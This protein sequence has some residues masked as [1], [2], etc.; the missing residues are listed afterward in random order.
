[1]RFVRNTTNEDN[2]KNEPILS[3]KPNIVFN[4]DHQKISPPN[5]YPIMLIL[6]IL[7]RFRLNI[8]SYPDGLRPVIT[9]F[10]IFSNPVWI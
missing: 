5:G 3:A 9:A 1:M 8:Q 7:I 4:N 2:Y 10:V 6:E